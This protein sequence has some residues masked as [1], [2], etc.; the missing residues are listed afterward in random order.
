MSQ[1][2]AQFSASRSWGR[3][4]SGPESQD[5]SSDGVDPTF[6]T[7]LIGFGGVAVPQRGQ[8]E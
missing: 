4:F 5:E 2:S 7:C 1:R 6:A 3:Q 8:L